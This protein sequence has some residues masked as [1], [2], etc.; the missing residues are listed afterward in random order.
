MGRRLQPIAPSYAEHQAALARWRASLDPCPDAERYTDAHWLAV[1]APD[2]MLPG[3]ARE[4]KIVRTIGAGMD[5]AGVRESGWG[6][7]R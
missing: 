1:H 6:P 7:G 3:G 2:F 4:R 5:Y